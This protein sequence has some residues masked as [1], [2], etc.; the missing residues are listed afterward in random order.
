M[1]KKTITRPSNAAAGSKL[2]KAKMFNAA[3]KTSVT[4]VN[5]NKNLSNYAKGKSGKKGCQ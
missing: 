2:P 3:E 5:P 4:K 1:T